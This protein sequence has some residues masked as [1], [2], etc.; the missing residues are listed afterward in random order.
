MTRRTAPEI[1][2]FHFGADIRE[3]SDSRYQPTRYASPGLYVIGDDYY[4]SP[5][6]SQ[7]PPPDY[8]W[9]KVG[10]YYGREVL[11]AGASQ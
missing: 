8:T 5:T 2:A 3:V 9:K 4:C 10:E 11:R 6:A 1:I 7:K